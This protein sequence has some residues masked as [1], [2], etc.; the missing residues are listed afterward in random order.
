MIEY[1]SGAAWT[2]PKP[3][4]NLIGMRSGDF[5]PGLASYSSREDDS[6][7]DMI[8]L[9]SDD[10]PVP[11]ASL[12]RDAGLHHELQRALRRLNDATLADSALCSLVLVRQLQQSLG[13][14]AAP[15]LRR[16]LTDLIDTLAAANEEGATILR[17]HYVDGVEVFIIARELAQVE[18][19]INRKQRLAIAELADLLQV[20]EEAARTAGRQQL[21]ARLEAPTY[22]RLFG[23]EARVEEIDTV[24]RRAG[25]PWL[26]SV[27]GAGGIGKTALADWLVR[28]RTADAGWQ[29]VAWVTARQQILNA[30]GALRPT[31]RP[32]LTPAALVDALYEQLLAIPG[33]PAPAAPE[34]QR[35]VR[36]TL[37]AQPHLVVVDNLETVADLDALLDMLADLAAPTKF[38]I[39]TRHSLHHVAG[40]YS[41]RTPELG[42]ADAAAL[43][44]W[45]AEVRNLPALAAAGDAELAAIYAVAGGNPL[46]LRLVAGQTH[47]H[48]LDTVLD[49]LR[50]A[51]GMAAEAL[52]THIYRSAWDQLDERSRQVLLLMPLVSE[53]GG[54]K[55]FLQAV[56]GMEPGAL[57][58]A[59]DRLITLNLVDSRGDLYARSYS[60]HSLTRSF[61]LQ[62]VLKW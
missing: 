15:A 54:G 53:S 26:V 37:K 3:D 14:A 44:R 33:V 29:R 23:V 59:L 58:D 48:T 50:E 60:I 61:L 28:T 47:L 49:N 51:R 34:R 9:P 46:A 20:S 1:C 52:Y 8:G 22:T 39:T 40:I 30:G 17:R 38:L 25:P 55:D 10:E 13:L 57:W 12:P 18:G 43:I 32:V 62:Q 11:P 45:E 6:T 42:P 31:N 41:Y 7:I 21:L 56:S 4:R 2:Y 16:C 19:T 24:L 5:N 36:A 35:R 27:D